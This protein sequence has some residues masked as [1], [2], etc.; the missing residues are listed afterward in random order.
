MLSDPL[1]NQR[2][3]LALLP[4]VVFHS[5]VDEVDGRFRGDELN[6]LVDERNL[7]WCPGAVAHRLVFLEHSLDLCCGFGEEREHLVLSARFSYDSLFG[8]DGLL[9]DIEVF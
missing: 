8:Y 9:E 6:F 2:E 5:E 4:Q 1:C 7:G 3:V